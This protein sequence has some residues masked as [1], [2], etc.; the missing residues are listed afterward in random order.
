MTSE[1]IFDILRPIIISVTGVTECILEV[2]GIDSPAPSP[3]SEYAVV[4]PQQSITERG[5]ANIN[6]KAGALASTQDIDVRAQ[7][8]C[9]AWVNFY[10]GDATNRAS[11]LKQCNKRSDISSALF[12][13][14]LG[15]LGTSPV[16]NLT[17]LQFETVE[18]RAQIAITL[19]YET[20]DPIVIN[21]I[22]NVPITVEYEN[23]DI[24]TTVNIT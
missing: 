20:S 9:T 12:R 3:T 24:I 10:R 14:G 1:E 6:R 19:A 13:A 4:R 21:S 16:N 5:Q 11:K 8:I 15:W 18:S 2:T 7:I 17:G 23:G 22:D